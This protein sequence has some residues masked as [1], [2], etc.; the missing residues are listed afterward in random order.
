MSQ[1]ITKSIR[2]TTD[3]A[4][5]QD[6]QKVQTPAIMDLRPPNQDCILDRVSAII[7]ETVHGLLNS[8]LVIDTIIS[9]IIFLLRSKIDLVES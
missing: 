9:N 7:E 1:R 6:F 3:D 5:K 4:V 8:N 2:L